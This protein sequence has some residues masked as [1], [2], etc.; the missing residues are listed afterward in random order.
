MIPMA[1]PERQHGALLDT[2]NEQ[3]EDTKGSECQ[4]VA[5]FEGQETV[6]EGPSAGAHGHIG[7]DNDELGEGEQ[8]TV[9]PRRSEGE[10]LCSGN[11][12]ASINIR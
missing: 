9:R 10:C 6:A 12:L 11:I 1:L 7:P 8:S 5:G 3:L 2:P 4:N